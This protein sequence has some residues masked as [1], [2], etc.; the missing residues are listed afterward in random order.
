MLN[1]IF[2]LTLILFFTIIGNIV[3]SFFKDNNNIIYLSPIIGLTS[4]CVV[5]I[6]ISSFV[7][8][9]K[10]AYL[11]L[12]IVLM[13]FI[14]RFKK[15]IDLLEKQISN[16]SFMLLVV[17]SVIVFCLPV[18]QNLELVSFTHTN[19][20]LIYYLAD[21]EWLTNH[22][23]FEKP[24]FDAISPYYYV[25]QN[26]YVHYSRL[27]FDVVGSLIMNIFKLDA[28]QIF[29]SYTVCIITCQNIVFVYF[30]Q[31]IFKLNEKLSWCLGAMLIISLNSWNMLGFEYGPQIFGVM[32][33]AGVIFGLI[34]FIKE[35]SNVWFVFTI[36]MFSANLGVYSE[37]AYYLFFIFVIIMIFTICFYRKKEMLK[38]RIRGI[39]L[40]GISG[41]IICI[42]AT[43]KVIRYYLYLLDATNSGVESLNADGWIKVENSDIL[44]NIF[45]LSFSPNS[46]VGT[47]FAYIGTGIAY[48]I[49]II[50]VIFLID[51][52]RRKKEFAI[53]AYIGI[54][55]FFIILEIVFAA[56][57]FD[58]GEYKHLI[59]IQPFIYL[60]LFISI[61]QLSETLK[62]GVFV[63]E[64]ILLVILLGNI[65][66][67]Q[68]CFPLDS[69]NVYGADLKEL[70]QVS[71][72]FDD[73]LNILI[74]QEYECDEQHQIIY[75]LKDCNLIIPGSSY[76]YK[77]SEHNIFSA[78]A[79]I[80]DKEKADK[81]YM[82]GNLLYSTNK[83]EIYSFDYGK[84]YFTDGKL[85]LK[86]TNKKFETSED[87][88][89]HGK[90]IFCMSE[91][92]GFKIWGPYIQVPRGKYKIDSSM[93]LL[94]DINNQ[95]VIGRFQICDASKDEVLF[96]KEI[97]SEET[98]ID[99]WEF[100]LNED[101][102]NIEFRYY[103]ESG[104]DICIKNLAITKY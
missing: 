15:I 60:L 7:A 10:N 54:I 102:E 33:M 71:K 69:Y 40:I 91:K 64:A 66:Q 35:L 47:S 56:I 4:V 16:I 74:P 86:L 2:S 29:L 18:I 13:L 27:G 94:N 58:Y 24:T 46:D 44:S 17:V 98:D 87:C 65:L 70:R 97:T 14:I 57:A 30:A 90:E 32:C 31:Y 1:V 34:A 103:I 61:S 25:T 85:D 81:Q 21:M 83:F 8:V 55:V 95:D 79:V 36:L 93:V 50:L 92:A 51:K 19:N 67:I 59:S 43:Y 53:V 45:G 9:G 89:K 37:F 104:V 41:L 6:N 75:A 22:T 68:N 49:A 3:L 42:P 48:I 5:L 96:E 28:Y 76:Y 82:K 62:S 39:C 12:I 38:K 20:D 101:Y 63:S 99:D 84:N 73:D 88:L 23:Y 26:M 77:Y 11:F 80:I 72:K 100:E 78:N 52:L